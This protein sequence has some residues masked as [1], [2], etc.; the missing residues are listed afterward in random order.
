VSDCG[1]FDRHRAAG[2]KDVGSQITVDKSKGEISPFIVKALHE[3]IIVFTG[4]RNII[5]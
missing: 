2:Q 5:L 3:S 1:N 4:Q